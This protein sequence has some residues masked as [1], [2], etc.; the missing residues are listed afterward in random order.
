MFRLVI[1]FVSLFVASAVFQQHTQAQ[2]G[3][4]PILDPSN[5][6]LNEYLISHPYLEVTEDS[7][8]E[9]SI[10][11]AP[12]IQPDNVN[13]FYTSVKTFT[14][15]DLVYP[16]DNFEPAIRVNRFQEVVETPGYESLTTTWL[17]QDLDGNVWKFGELRSGEY[18]LPGGTTGSVRGGW[19]YG[20]SSISNGISGLEGT[21]LPGYYLAADPRDTTIWIQETAWRDEDS[22]LF[23]YYRETEYLQEMDSTLWGE[24]PYRR[25][26]GWQPPDG[27]TSSGVEATI[28]S[29]STLFGDGVGETRHKWGPYTQILTDYRAT[30]EPTCLWFLLLLPLLLIR[31]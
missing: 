1:L 3:I 21:D 2:E 11:I 27:E 18:I 4:L 26:L 12:F 14:G 30:P 9:Y 22:Q 5:F 20:S 15:Y 24:G 8:W 7:V 31:K 29:G 25:W 19:L 13:E 6:P 17:G 28:W 16:W 10:G 23:G